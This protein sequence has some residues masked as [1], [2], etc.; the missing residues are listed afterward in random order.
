M[1][2][3]RQIVPL[4]LSERTIM[5]DRS[6]LAEIAEQESRHRGVR[7]GDIKTA[8]PN[9]LGAGFEPHRRGGTGQ[10]AQHEK[11][12]APRYEAAAAERAGALGSIQ[13]AGAQPRDPL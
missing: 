2:K 11:L 3:T 6:G 8:V 9:Q 12:A 13:Q 10:F 4:S 5:A 7:R 1:N